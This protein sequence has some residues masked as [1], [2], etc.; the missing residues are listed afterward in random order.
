MKTSAKM[1]LA[2]L[3]CF[4]ICGIEIVVTGRCDGGFMCYIIGAVIGFAIG[5]YNKGVRK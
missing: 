1:A 3:A 5:T 4:V 2:L